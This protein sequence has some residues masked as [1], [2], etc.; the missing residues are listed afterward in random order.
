MTVTL[1]REVLD[2]MNLTYR[3]NEKKAELV[4]KAKE[5]RSVTIN[6]TQDCDGGSEHTTKSSRKTPKLKWPI[7]YYYDEKKERLFYLLLHILF[8]L[9]TIGAFID[10][11]VCMYVISVLS[12]IRFIII[13]LG[14]AALFIILQQLM[15]LLLTISLYAKVQ[16]LL[17]EFFREGTMQPLS[18]F[19]V[20]S[21]GLCPHVLN[22]F[23]LC[24]TFSNFKHFCFWLTFTWDTCGREARTET[25]F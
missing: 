24:I 25:N 14:I 8:L 13:R 23:P 3:K 11:L 19:E 1:L 20:C 12:T 9:D 16:L 6:A 15:L 7:A 10:F 22:S 18:I 4:R 2:E 21:I 5:A 17:P